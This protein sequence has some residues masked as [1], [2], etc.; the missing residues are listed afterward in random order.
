MTNRC[1]ICKLPGEFNANMV[2]VCISRA[3]TTTVIHSPQPMPRC[4]ASAPILE[5][6]SSSS[7]A[8]GGTR[9]RPPV[10][11]GIILE[12]LYADARAA[13]LGAFNS[14]FNAGGNAMVSR[15]T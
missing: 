2:A 3:R 10:P 1:I 9:G 8:R 5:N 15:I 4:W 12:A 6:S 13:Y 14:A 11:A 7:E